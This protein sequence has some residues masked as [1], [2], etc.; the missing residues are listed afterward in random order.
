MKYLTNIDFVL[1]CLRGRS[2][3]AHWASYVRSHSDDEQLNRAL[4][5]LGML[6]IS[7]PKMSSD[8]RQSLYDSIVTDSNA[9]S[10]RWCGSQRM[11]RRLSL[12]VA[13][14]AVLV[15][16]VLAAIKIFAVEGKADAQLLPCVSLADVP[17]PDNIRVISGQNTFDYNRLVVARINCAQQG[18]ITLNEQVVPQVEQQG[19][20]VLI[21]SNHRAIVTLSDN[22]KVWLN[23]NTK[24]RVGEFSDTSRSV[25]IDGDAYFEVAHNPKAPFVV[26]TRT[27][28]T[29]VKGTSFNIYS[30]SDPSATHYVVLVEG[31][32]EV[33]MPTIGQSVTLAPSQIISYNNDSYLTT[34]TDVSRYIGWHDGAL[35]VDSDSVADVVAK[36]AEYYGVETEC[37]NDVSSLSCSGRLVLF[38]DINQTLT[39]LESIIPIKYKWN[40]GKLYISL[41]K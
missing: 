29:I 2:S 28:N 4:R 24:M 20:E 16:G 17:M 1:W 25:E 3:S 39:V 5:V 15:V 40:S 19:M 32:V 27:L 26:Y 36:L 10:R 33:D 31:S 37:D 18:V 6:S 41:E 21:P 38:D 8:E 14:C 13:A 23:G 7:K 12:G 34:N 30:T 9:A 35:T 11:W 22:T